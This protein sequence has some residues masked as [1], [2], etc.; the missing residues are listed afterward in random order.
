MEDIKGIK[1]DVRE[2]ILE[3]IDSMSED[4]YLKKER[5]VCNRLFEL[6][7]FMEAKVVLL[8]FSRKGEVNSK[9]IIK[10]ALDL[11]K[12]V[13]IP[14]VNN[15]KFNIQLMKI[16]DPEKDMIIDEDNIPQ[17]DINKCKKVPMKSID[18]AVIPGLAFDE[19]GGR[20][21]V[22]DGY[23]DRLI[24]KLPATTRAVALALEEQIVSQ[25]SMD[26]HDKY[27]DIIVTGKR[28]IYKI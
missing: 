16:T 8:Y 13:V 14:V 9:K 5:D 27:V 15:D 11:G 10:K 21:G 18:I 7:N 20:V 2:S 3:K 19:K 1:R 28:I 12:I 23:Y 24:P 26:S 25:V 6:A 22:G 4:L 17:P